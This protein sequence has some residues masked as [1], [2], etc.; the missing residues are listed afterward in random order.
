[1]RRAVQK[2]LALVLA[3]GLVASGPVCTCAGTEPCSS[4][5]AHETSDVPIYADLSVDLSDKG[6]SQTEFTADVA[7]HDSHCLVEKSASRR[8]G[9][10][11]IGL[12]AHAL[13]TNLKPRKC[14]GALFFLAPRISS[15]GR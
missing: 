2:L 7:H 6:S 11:R 8:K 9:D 3:A 12:E 13:A 5:A 14:S 15:V 4:A 10:V 1:M